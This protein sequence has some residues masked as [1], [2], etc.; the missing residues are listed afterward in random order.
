MDKGVVNYQIDLIVFI[1]RTLITP[2]ISCILNIQNQINYMIILSDSKFLVLLLD[3]VCVRIHY[4][5]SFQI[6]TSSIRLA[7][8]A[9]NR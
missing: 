3:R 7:G 2:I 9:V 5:L 8:L 4:E 1:I 6:V